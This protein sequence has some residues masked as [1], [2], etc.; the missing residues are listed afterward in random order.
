MRW[1]SPREPPFTPRRALQPPNDDLGGEWVAGG[2]RGR[3]QL[4]VGERPPRP[5]PRRRRR[6]CVGL[7]LTPAA[8]RPPRV[9]STCARAPWL[10]EPSS[11]LHN[12]WERRASRG[13]PRP[14]GAP[15]PGMGTPAAT[16][17]APPPLLFAAPV[18]LA[19]PRPGS[20]F[21][22]P[23]THRPARFTASGRKCQLT[24]TKANNGYVGAFFWRE[25]R[26]RRK[27][28]PPA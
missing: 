12:P 2:R 18:S 17:A 3:A 24:G 5:P 9:A 20:P 25:R 27:D 14:A 23:P 26:K 21:S 13:D 28:D 22:P 4:R 11:A 10:C 6:L 8:R 15:R 1:E 16:Y 7:A 19:P